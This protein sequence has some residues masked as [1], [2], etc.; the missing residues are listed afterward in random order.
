MYIVYSRL[1]V[2]LAFPAGEAVGVAAAAGLDGIDDV[3]MVLDFVALAAVDPSQTTTVAAVRGVAD[4]VATAV[5]FVG[6][7]RCPVA[8]RVPSLVLGRASMGEVLEVTARIVTRFQC[9]N[10]SQ[11]LRT[12]PVST[13]F[14]SLQIL[15]TA[16]IACFCHALATLS[17]C[18]LVTQ[19]LCAFVGKV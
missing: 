3:A 4:A 9:S 11:L 19:V 14:L 6:I 18:S 13:A 17:A 12:L 8:M 7:E 15:R 16:Y 2:V 5:H 10:S 1:C